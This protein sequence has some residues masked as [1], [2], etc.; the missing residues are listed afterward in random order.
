M[1]GDLIDWV[2][3]DCAALNSVKNQGICFFVFKNFI[4]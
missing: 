3:I 4:L 2:R 1:A